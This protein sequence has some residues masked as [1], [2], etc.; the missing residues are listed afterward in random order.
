MGGKGRSTG[1]LDKAAGA[2]NSWHKGL[3]VGVC[4][5]CRSDREQVTVT[6]TDGKWVLVGIRPL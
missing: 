6:G 2:G 1:C 5:A 4:L 3:K